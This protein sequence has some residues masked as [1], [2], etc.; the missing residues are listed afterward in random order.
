MPSE[1]YDVFQVR[2]HAESAD[3]VYDYPLATF[4]T[5]EKAANY[6]LESTGMKVNDGRS[7]CFYEFRN[8]RKQIRE[9]AEMYIHG[10]VMDFP[11]NDPPHFE[12]IHSLSEVVI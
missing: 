10:D 2:V 12:D 5:K 8:A 9:Y 4:S 11:L 6:I 1:D 3:K 7:V